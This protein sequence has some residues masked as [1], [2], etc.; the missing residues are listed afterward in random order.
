MAWREERHDDGADASADDVSSSV[1]ATATATAAAVARA[2]A[3][4]VRVG[5]VRGVDDSSSTDGSRLVTRRQ[6]DCHYHARAARIQRVSLAVQRTKRRQ[7]REET[8]GQILDAAT[9]L[10]RERSFRELSVDDLM[11]RTGHTRTLFYR[12]FADI[13]ALMLALIED[14]SADLVAVAQQWAQSEHTG[15]DEA[16]A[17]LAAFVDFHTRNGPVITAVVEAAHHDDAVEEAYGSMVEGF[18]A[19]T[20]NAIQAHIDAGELRP[21]DA[22]EIARALVR[23]LNSY[24]GDS[25]RTSDPERALETV[26]TVWTRTLFPAG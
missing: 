6:G 11:A 24:L 2:S 26:W 21:I 12:H 18:V 22:P 4:A 7:Q 3:P 23:M 1:A 20:A 14:A 9:E 15:P 16:R 19:I 17:G 13:P 25:G 5:L 8:R 10:L